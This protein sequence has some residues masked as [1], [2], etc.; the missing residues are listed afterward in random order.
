MSRTYNSIFRSLSKKI[1][2]I[3][4]LIS[5]PVLFA[6]LPEKTDAIYSGI[7]WFDQ[8]GNVVSAHGAN[9]IKEKRTIVT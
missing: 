6:Q 3:I 1:V 5:T 2:C 4:F 7:P 8:N 9:I